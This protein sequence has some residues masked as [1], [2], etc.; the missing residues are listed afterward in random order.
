MTVENP[1]AGQ[2]SVVWRSIASTLQPKM[3]PHVTLMI[4]FILVIITLFMITTK[5]MIMS[6]HMIMRHTV[7]MWLSWP[8][9]HRSASSTRWS[10]PSWSRGTYELYR[11]PAGPVELTV[12]I[13]GG[14]VTEA[15]W[16]V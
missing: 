1:D 11:R 3:S 10:F 5:N 16:P 9:R 14:A 15:A 13:R 6:I 8:A 12:T 4:T 2:G 7:R